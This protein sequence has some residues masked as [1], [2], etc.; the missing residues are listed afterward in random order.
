MKP[1]WKVYKN[2][3][4]I[5]QGITW[6]RALAN[7]INLEAI[8]VFCCSKQASGL[9]SVESMHKETLS[10]RYKIVKEN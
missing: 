3:Y 10:N 2:D 9:Y 6:H 4:C 5:S 1:E 8:T 7:L